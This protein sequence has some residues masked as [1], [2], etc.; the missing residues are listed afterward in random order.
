MNKVENIER[1]L[2]CFWYSLA[3]L[4]PIFGLPLAIHALISSLRC[5]RAMQG[6]WNPARAY[7]DWALVLA[8]MGI[9]VS[10][11]TAFVFAALIAER[12]ET[13]HF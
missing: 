5:R 8:A 2:R 12:F 13:G 1:S 9:F 11:V 3:G 7:L 6:P 4:V 10:V